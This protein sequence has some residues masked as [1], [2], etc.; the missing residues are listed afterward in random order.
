[1]LPELAPSEPSTQN[2]PPNSIKLSRDFGAWLTGGLLLV[3]AAVAWVVVIQQGSPGGAGMDMGMAA[4]SLAGAVAYLGAW[5]VMMAAMM[6]PSAIPMIA[7]YG[8]MQRGK[9]K[10]GQRGL[11]AAL[12]T[13]VY[14]AAWL[15]FGIPVYVASVL[16][17]LAASSNPLVASWLPYGVAVVLVGAGIYQLSPLKR[18]CLRNCQSPF[19]FLMGH[20]RSGYAG[21]IRLAWDHALFCLGC[22]SALMIVLV[23]AG[24]MSLPWVLLIAALVFVEKVLPRGDWTARVI[25]AGLIVL[26]VLIVL[27]PD[28]AM[29]LRGTPM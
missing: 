3:L 15:A 26:G 20:W 16:L 23:V 10:T 22:C 1:M 24:A 2:T 6:L 29:T 28:L 4:F 27:R 11:L 18:T 17:G 13:L 19:G 25:G 9:A 12:F 7:L 21:A 14:L 8:A 5:G